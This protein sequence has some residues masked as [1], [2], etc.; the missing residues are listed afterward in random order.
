MAKRR[1]PLDQILQIPCT[2]SMKKEIERTADAEE[3]R[4]T[5]MG[6]ILWREALDA[7]KQ[8]VHSNDE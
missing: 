1:E 2:K 7:R 3:R 8:V 5:D 4:V 6:R